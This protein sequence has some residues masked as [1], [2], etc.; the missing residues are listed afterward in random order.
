MKCY[1]PLARLLIYSFAFMINLKLV[2][3]QFNRKTNAILSPCSNIN[4]RKFCIV[5]ACVCDVEK[6]KAIR[7]RSRF[8]LQLILQ[9]A[10]GFSTLIDNQGQD[11]ISDIF[12]TITFKITISITP[13]QCICVYIHYIHCTQLQSH[14]VFILMMIPLNRRT[15]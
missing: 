4:Q 14:A 5:C 8:L 15:F 10:A 9:Y 11:I 3:F 1:L 7:N 6:V 13:V 12:I 2:S